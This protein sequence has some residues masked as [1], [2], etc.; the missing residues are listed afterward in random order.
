MNDWETLR[1]GIEEALDE[2]QRGIALAARDFVAWGEAKTEEEIT[3]LDIAFSSSVVAAS[4]LYRGVAMLAVQV[5]A[6]KEVV[7][8]SLLPGKGDDDEK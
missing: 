8:L 3:S 5:D 6:M 4:A 1:Q 7:A 2:A